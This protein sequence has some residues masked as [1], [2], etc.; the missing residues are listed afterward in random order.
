MK[1]KN[2]THNNIK[3][4]TYI[5]DTHAYRRKIHVDEI[6]SPTYETKCTRIHSEM[7]A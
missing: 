7:S 4:N 5:K 3:T 1:R 6:N 2:N